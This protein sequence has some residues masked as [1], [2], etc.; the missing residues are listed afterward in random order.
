MKMRPIEVIFY[1]E[2]LSNDKK[3][4]E[5]AMEQTVE[6]LKAEKGVEIKDIYV[7]EIVEDPR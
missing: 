1:I 2:G 3:A 5:S 6:S 7:D 4:L